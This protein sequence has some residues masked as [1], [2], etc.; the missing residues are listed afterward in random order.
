MPPPLGV[1]GGSLFQGDIRNDGEHG[2]DHVPGAAQK[3][4]HPGGKR[5]EKRDVLRVFAQ[6]AF[7]KLHHDV[8]ATRGLQ[9]SGT[10]YHRENG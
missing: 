9:G 2:V 5:G 7:S 6:Q 1:P 8:E 4:Q 3:G 10:A